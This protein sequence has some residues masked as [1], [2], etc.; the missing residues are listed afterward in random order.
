[1]M[2]QIGFCFVF[3]VSRYMFLYMHHFLYLYLLLSNFWGDEIRMHGVCVYYKSIE[4]ARVGLMNAL[5][6]F[7]I[8]NV[9][10]V[11]FLQKINCACMGPFPR[12][13]VSPLFLLLTPTLNT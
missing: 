5:V 7:L 8:V 10:E 1:M 13:F 6:D 9:H 12:N 2:L 4:M 11:N 3:R